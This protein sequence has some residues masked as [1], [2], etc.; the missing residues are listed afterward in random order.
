MT[1]K[2]KSLHSE[3]HFDRIRRFLTN[4][5]YSRSKSCHPVTS[6]VSMDYTYMNILY[7]SI[8][9]VNHRGHDR[10][11]KN[12]GVRE[13]DPPHPTPPA[14]HHSLSLSL[15]LQCFSYLCR[16]LYGS[17]IFCIHLVYHIYIYIPFISTIGRVLNVFN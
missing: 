7:E 4:S 15:S 12:S 6:L 1:S 14:P 13:D 3:A 10:G 8:I 5:D 16:G 17:H 9:Y 11:K 2:V